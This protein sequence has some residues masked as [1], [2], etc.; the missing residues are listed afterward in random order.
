MK[1]GTGVPTG[2]AITVVFGARHGNIV[3]ALVRRSVKLLQ[4]P[5]QPAVVQNVVHELTA[6]PTL[7]PLEDAG[8]VPA[9][10][11]KRL[12]SISVADAQADA[13]RREIQEAVPGVAE[14][15]LHGS[16]RCR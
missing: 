3:V 4:H 7:H 6:N 1:I 10:E 15:Y 2:G 16:L 8:T 11:A 13:N 12:C 14:H 5:H 9:G